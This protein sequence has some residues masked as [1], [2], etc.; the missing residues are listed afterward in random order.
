[1][2]ASLS[3]SHGYGPSRVATEK[4]NKHRDD[5]VNAKLIPSILPNYI[6][7]LAGV[8]SRDSVSRDS[9]YIVIT[10]YL[11]N[12][13]QV[14]R[15]QLERIPTLKISDYNLG[16]RNNYGMLAHHK[17]LTKTKGNNLKIIP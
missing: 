17:Y 8:V 16:D 3:T 2:Q 7:P 13:I 15:L 12:G 6:P 11:P 4:R 9:D 1:V 14:V 5:L 10:M